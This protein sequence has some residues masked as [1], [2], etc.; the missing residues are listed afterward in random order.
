MNCIYEDETYNFTLAGWKYNH[1]ELKGV[2]IRLEVG[3]RDIK[4][5]QYVAVRRDTREKITMR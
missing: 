1:W 2:P 5:S 4:N 3:P